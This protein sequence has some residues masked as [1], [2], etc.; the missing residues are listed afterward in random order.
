MLLS[1]LSDYTFM[2]LPLHSLYKTMQFSDTLHAGLRLATVA[3]IRYTPLSNLTS[4][5]FSIISNPFFPHFSQLIKVCLSVL[6]VINL[7]HIYI[8]H[9]LPHLQRKL[10]IQKQWKARPQ[11]TWNISYPFWIH[12]SRAIPWRSK[13]KQKLPVYASSCS[14]W[15]TTR[16][17]WWILS[18]S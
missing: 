6:S 18:F 16:R 4:N 2:S 5:R 8:N 7:F 12:L 9:W 1:F 3:R 11:L 10:R 17:F 13:A 14:R 15:W